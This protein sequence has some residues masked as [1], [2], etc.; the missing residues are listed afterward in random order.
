MPSSPASWHLPSRQLEPEQRQRQ[1]QRWKVA[2]ILSIATTILLGIL[3]SMVV[4]FGGRRTVSSVTTTRE[5]TAASDSTSNTIGSRRNQQDAR[6]SDWEQFLAQKST[7][8]TVLGV[9]AT[10]ATAAAAVVVSD[11][12]GSA[13]TTPPPLLYFNNSAAFAR[14]TPADDFFHY[15]NGWEAQLTQVRFVVPVHRGVCVY[16]SWF[17]TI[18]LLL[19]LLTPIIIQLL[20]RGTQGAVRNRHDR[21]D[22]KFL[23]G[24]SYDPGGGRLSITD[25]YHICTV[26]L[27]RSAVYDRHGTVPQSVCVA[28]RGRDRS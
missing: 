4:D 1:R 10:P 21:C 3:G 19:C 27:G 12:D 18:C 15:Q 28:G 17:V 5:T 22:V 9:T 14:V 6:Y 8:T 20:F 16:I 25:G 23:A 26:S 11:S 24:Y 7:A 2:G 13:T